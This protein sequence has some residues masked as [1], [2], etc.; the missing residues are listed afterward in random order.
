MFS[1]LKNK[2]ENRGNILAEFKGHSTDAVKIM[3]RVLKVVITAR[4]KRIN[5]I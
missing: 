1:Y 4:T 3:L 5:A 2:E